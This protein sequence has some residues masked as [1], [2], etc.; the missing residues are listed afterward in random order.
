VRCA[1]EESAMTF[2][3]CV[4]KIQ[5]LHEQASHERVGDRSCT[6]RTDNCY[7]LCHFWMWAGN[8][9]KTPAIS[10]PQHFSFWFTWFRN[11]H[12]FISALS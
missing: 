4:E 11:I 9:L 5:K 2:T 1:D 8:F 6:E 7:W 10:H 3:A 12:M